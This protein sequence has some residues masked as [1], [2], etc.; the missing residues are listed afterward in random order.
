MSSNVTSAET[1]LYIYLKEMIELC[2][3]THNKN[4]SSI[5]RSILESI[6]EEIQNLL[7]GNDEALSFAT[8]T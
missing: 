2:D 3:K 4:I 6:C 8:S 7:E 1:E 5:S